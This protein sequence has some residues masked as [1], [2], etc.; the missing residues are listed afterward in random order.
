MQHWETI[1]HYQAKE[2]T[3]PFG[4]TLKGLYQNGWF[5]LL[6]T[7]ALYT[8]A[9]WLASMTSGLSLLIVGVIST[10]MY[11]KCQSRTV[12]MSWVCFIE[13]PWSKDPKSGLLLTLLFGIT[14]IMF[15]VFFVTYTLISLFL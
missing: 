4:Y 13:N 7:V 2:P 11:I 6:A 14:G 3:S 9:W 15:I 1:L 5:F 10:S 12:F 8:S